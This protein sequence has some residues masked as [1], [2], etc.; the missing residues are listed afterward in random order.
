MS[1]QTR[2]P[3]PDL[4][5]GAALLSMLCY[6]ATFDAVLFGAKLP[7]LFGTAGTLWQVSIGCTFVAL[8]GFCWGFSRHPLRHAI[9]LLLCGFLVTLVTT[10]FLPSEQ[11]RC[12]VLTCLGLCALVAAALQKLPKQPKRPLLAATIFLALFLLFYPLQD[13]T[14]GFGKLSLS[15]P[16]ALYRA[17]FGYVLGLP[18]P[19]F[20]SGDYYP[21]IPWF[22]LYLAGHFLRLWVL[23]HPHTEQLLTHP[24]RTP[25]FTPLLWIGQ[26]SLLLY[27]LHQPILMAVF[28]LIT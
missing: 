18:S 16:S 15:L 19:R 3:L 1:R 13:G 9:T 14:L 27:L 7:W 25:M 12:G 24:K 22:F 26:H 4:L 17:K 10:L 21:L 2:Y 6:H 11:I 5:R 20:F 23:Q 28:Y 8:S